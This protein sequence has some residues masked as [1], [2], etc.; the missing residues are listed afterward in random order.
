MPTY[1][2]TTI[3]GL[4]SAWE[5]LNETHRGGNRYS[6]GVHLRIYRCLS[7]AQRAEILHQTDDADIAL[8]L[9]IVGFNSLW[10]RHYEPDQPRSGEHETWSRFLVAIARFD[11]EHNQRL[12]TLFTE[13]LDLFQSIC[14]SPFFHREFWVEPGAA[15]LAENREIAEKIRQRLQT[16]RSH[17]LLWEFS[18]RILL[19][20]GQVIHGNATLGGSLNRD[21]VLAASRALDLLLRTILEVVIIDGAHESDLG[22]E[23]VP[24]D[25]GLDIRMEED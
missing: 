25:P 22:W 16:G 7:W 20:R 23:P 12:A 17:S 5:P 3:A 21:T 24:Y 9:R 18:R 19:L 1:E 13:E 15:S 14:D 10:G 8:I 2:I 11:E 6:S 4:R